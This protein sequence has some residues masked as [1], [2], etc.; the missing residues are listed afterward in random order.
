MI[1][2]YSVL[3]PNTF[4]S[5]LAYMIILIK[6]TKPPPVSWKHLTLL[7]GS[8]SDS[9][10]GAQQVQ[11]PQRRVHLPGQSVQLHQGLPGLVGRAPQG[12]R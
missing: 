4:V 10:R 1:S 11:V 6:S 12:L 9:L 3:P 8:H 7:C 5:I 2:N